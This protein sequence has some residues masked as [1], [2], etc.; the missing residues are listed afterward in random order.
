MLLTQ[1]T[2]CHISYEHEKRCEKGALNSYK[3]NKIRT[4]IPVLDEQKG[5]KYVIIKRTI[6]YTA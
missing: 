5:L 6:T 1:S 4:V 2:L 3:N